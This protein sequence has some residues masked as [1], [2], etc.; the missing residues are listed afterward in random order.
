M[1][2]YDRFAF[3]CDAR[4]RQPD[5][6]GYF[7]YFGCDRVVLLQAELRFAILPGFSLGRRLG[8]DFDVLSTPE[9]VLFTD[10]GRAWIEPESVGYRRGLGPESVHWDAGA[11]LRLGRL[12]LY[13]ATPLQ[14]GGGANFFVRLGPRL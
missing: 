10:G 5:A 14:G 4:A 9:I 13:V 2:G 12:G 11:G 1:P 3:D 7:P 6:D 8:V